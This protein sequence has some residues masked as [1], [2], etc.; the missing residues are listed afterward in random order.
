MFAPFLLV[1]LGWLVEAVGL[2]VCYA[3]G[4]ATA[5]SPPVRVFGTERAVY[6]LDWGSMACHAENVYGVQMSF[7][8]G[9][10][11]EKMCGLQFGILASGYVS[12]E[13]PFDEYHFCNLGA[14]RLYGIQFGLFAA[15]TVTVGGL[16]LSCGYSE[17]RTVNG[18]Q[19]GLVN[20]TA[21]LHGLQ[22]G[23]YNSAARGLGLQ[24][25]LVN[26]AAQGLADY[27]P[28]LNFVY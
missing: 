16:Q 3:L 11:E 9:G 27:L 18:L 6:G 26:H 13:L 4:C 7:C 22:V 8:G 1:G 19:F 28:V 17:A 15:K 25:G 12:E 24:I 23:L 20:S 14:S 10:V 5:Y 21:K 2:P